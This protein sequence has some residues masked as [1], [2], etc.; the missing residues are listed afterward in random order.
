[1]TEIKKVAIVGMGAL[2][3]L[4]GDHIR[5]ALGPGS[6]V[7][8]V[9][10]ERA[11]RYKGARLTING[12]EIPVDVVSAEDAEPAD[13][14]IVA[15]KYTGLEAAIEVMRSC[16]DEHTTI[17]SVMNGISSEKILAEH[18]GR[19]KIIYTVAQG[20]DAMRFGYD[21]TYTQMGNIHIGMSEGTDRDRYDSLVNFFEKI[22]MPH[23]VEEDILWRM[24]FK[25]M[26]NVGINQICMVYN[27]PYAGAIEKGEPNRTLVAAMREVRAIAELEGVRL[28][29]DDLTRCIEIEKTLDPAGTPSM[30]QDRIN[31]KHSEVDMFAGEVIRLAKKHGILVPANEFLY[32]QVQLIEQE[33]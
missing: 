12:R 8:A 25:F 26:L 32:E 30:G 11:E 10:A 27:V 5:T 1:M 2:G 19:E 6:V 29:E 28:T 17:I 3:M 21:L 33:Y 31:R 22:K 4:Y 14:L 13:L 9:D 20:M 24:W 16:V 23:V 18:F 7:Y 15:V